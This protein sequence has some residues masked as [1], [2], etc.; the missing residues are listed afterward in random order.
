[1]KVAFS[2]IKYSITKTS[3]KSKI[4]KSIEDLFISIRQKR[5]IAS[6]RENSTFS[7]RWKSE[8]FDEL[9]VHK[10]HEKIPGQTR[11]SIKVEAR[12]PTSDAAH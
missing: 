8:T 1:M 6:W 4:S 11:H 9:R 10:C 5:Y 2:W 12:G 3:E 7:A